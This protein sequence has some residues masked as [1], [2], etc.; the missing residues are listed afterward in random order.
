MKAE[1]LLEIKNLHVSIGEKEIIKGLHLTINH[2][3]IHAIFGPNGSG[4]TTLLN[5]LMG[6]SGYEITGEI[7]F[8]GKKM[9]RLPINERAE[10]G[11]GMSFQRPPAIRGLQLR[12]LIEASTE[13]NGDLI[14]K[15]AKALNLI[16]FLNR[17]V[18][19]G[20][21]GGEIKRAELL[22]LLIQDPDLIL[23]DEPESGVDIDNI[24]LI[25]EYTNQLLGRRVER[26]KRKTMK[27]QHRE[28]LKSGLIITHTGHILE[29]IDADIGHILMEGRFACQANPRE[30]FRTLKECG[31]NEC[32][33]CFRK[34]EAHG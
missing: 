30:M 26:G 34:E 32:Y 3:E 24:V 9:T 22:Q 7:L 29:Y 11:I 13:R 8:R 20:F 19:V 23:L 4:K 6:F 10:M 2:G 25:G 1:P 21:S 17:E 14:E 31:F 5:A 18:N 12:K 28:K 16:D 27:E 15:Y 33:R